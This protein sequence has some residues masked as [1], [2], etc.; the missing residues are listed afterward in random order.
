MYV[1]DRFLNPVPVG[2]PGEL[3]IAGAGVARGYHGRPA[4][5]AGAFVADPFAGDGSRLYRTGDLARWRQDGQLDYLGRIDQQVKLRGFRIEPGE[6]EAALAAHPGVAAAVVAVAG[7]GTAARLAAWLIPADS[8]AGL[9]PAAELRGYLRDQLPD[10]MIPATYTELTGFPLTPTGKIDRAVLPAPDAGWPELAGRFVAPATPAEEL[11]AGIWA[12]VLGIGDVGAEDDFFE[13]GG[14]SLLAI[15]V[16]SRVRE[17]F[18]AEVPVA[19]LFDH[20]T[21]TRLAAVIEGPAV[22]IPAPPVEPADRDQRLP[23][24]FA[25]QRLWFLDQIDS[26][27]A[28]Y[29]LPMPLGMGDVDAS[30]LRAAL[31]AMVARHEVLR[32]RLVA[33]E[34]GV[35]FQVIDPPSAFPLPVADVSGAADPRRAVRELLAADAAAPFDLAAGPL[36][37]ACLARPGVGLACAGA[38]GA[39]RGVRRMV[40]RDLPA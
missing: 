13:L 32:T 26:G 21:V 23:L 12:Q 5:T 14:H 27:S 39:P 35:P 36:I 3:L 19:A 8:A 38:V 31:G 17:V 9:P 15:Q 10:Y 25:Q 1:V 28:E 22:G 4:L 20:P 6:V 37:R 7:P 33:G 18:G 29:N 30:A 11:L 40:G 16:I 24:S 2:V 34:D